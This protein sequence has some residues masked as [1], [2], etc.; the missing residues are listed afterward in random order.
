[1]N[2]TFELVR[3]WNEFQKEDHNPVYLRAQQTPIEWKSKVGNSDMSSNFKT[4]HDVPLRKGDMVIREDGMV[5]LLN[6]NVQNNPNNQASQSIECNATLTIKREVS[7]L[8]DDYGYLIEPAGRKVIV[9]ELPCVHADYAGRPDY[10]IS[11]GAVG[12]TPDHLIT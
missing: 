3:D 6:W 1:M 8:V 11:Q 12:I 2:Y 4:T 9:F 7:E 5:Y 10:V